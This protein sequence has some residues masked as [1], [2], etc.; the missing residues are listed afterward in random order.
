MIKLKYLHTY[1]DA[2]GT[3]RSYVRRKHSRIPVKGKIGSPSFMAA[4]RAAVRKVGGTL[5]PEPDFRGYPVGSHVYF[6][7]S[8]ALIKIG[9]TVNLSTRAIQLQVGSSE[10]LEL[11][12][13]L[14]GER[15]DEKAL[16]QQFQHLRVR[17]EWFRGDQ[18]LLSFIDAKR[19]DVG[20]ISG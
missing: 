10:P 4:Y 7:R 15:Q 12:L 19:T 3:F 5:D 9:W 2:T 20:R 1:R 6:M 8:G 16:H 17:G 14:P 11:M 18:E 13:A